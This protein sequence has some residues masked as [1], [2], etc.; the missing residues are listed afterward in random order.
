[1]CLRLLIAVRRN[2]YNMLYIT[3][4]FALSPKLLTGTRPETRPPFVY[5]DEDF[6]TLFQRLPRVDA[7]LAASI[8]HFGDVRIEGLKFMLIC[9]LSRFI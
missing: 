2:A 5:A 3:G 9:R 6:V 1:M 7:G 8:F 4:S